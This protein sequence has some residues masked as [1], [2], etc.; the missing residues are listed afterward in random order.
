M[1]LAR[2]GVELPAR[3]VSAAGELSAQAACH[4]LAPDRF[5]FMEI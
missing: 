5:H 3:R 1:I 4:V 2:A